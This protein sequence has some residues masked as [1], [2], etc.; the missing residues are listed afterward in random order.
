MK[1][2]IY[3]FTG[4]GNSLA[5][6]RKIAAALKDCDLVPIASLKDTPGTIVPAADRAGI[7]CPVYDAGLPVIVKEFA[8]RLDIGAVPYAFA[9]VTMGGMGVSALHQLNTILVQGCRKKLDAAFAV[10]MPGNFPPLAIPPAGEK[11]DEILRKADADLAAIAVAIQKG[12]PVPPGF[13]P[14][15]SLM[16]ILLYPPFARNVHGMSSSFSVED[17]CTGCGTC[18]KV[19]PVKNIVMEKD[20]PVWQQ[21]CELCCACLHFCPAEAI[22]LSLMRGSKGRGRYRHPDLTIDDMKAQRGE[23]SGTTP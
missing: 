13:S 11:K 1:T 17:T 10:S 20:R 5:A 8:E 12:Q 3:Y 15:S 9:I 18:A 23:K 2:V 21:T 22:Q 7:V 4:T 16:R 6:A 14:F 19:C